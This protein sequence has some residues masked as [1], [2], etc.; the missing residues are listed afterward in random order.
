MILRPVSVFACL[1]VQSSASGN[2]SSFG[3]VAARKLNSAWRK[4][5]LFHQVSAQLV[6]VR[7]ASAS[8]K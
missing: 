1:I 3:R 5:E 6:I 7:L 8:K 4:D 2:L